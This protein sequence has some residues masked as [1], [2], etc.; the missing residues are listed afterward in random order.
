MGCWIDLD[1]FSDLSKKHNNVWS[2]YM[3]VYSQTKY[4]YLWNSYWYVWHMTWYVWHMT[5]YVW[6]MTW[7]V[8]HTKYNLLNELNLKNLY[9][10]CGGICMMIVCADCPG[11]FP[12]GWFCGP[13]PICFHKMDGYKRYLNFKCVCIIIWFVYLLDHVVYITKWL[14]YCLAYKDLYISNFY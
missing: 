9:W 12:Y 1:I 14:S 5:W 3:S 13:T 2:I 7:Y 6:H 8:C 11:W 4:R 10:R